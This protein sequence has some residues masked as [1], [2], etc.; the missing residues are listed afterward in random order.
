MKYIDIMNLPS[1]PK[2]VLEYD[3]QCHFNVHSDSATL[4]IE[5][6]LR[7]PLIGS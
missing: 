1:H 6:V 7:C 3:S 5:H 2:A 4:S